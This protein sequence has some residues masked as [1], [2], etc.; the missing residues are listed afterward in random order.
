MASAESAQVDW[1]ASRFDCVERALRLRQGPDPD[2]NI[3]A[4]EW[5][6]PAISRL[7]HGL[8]KVNKLRTE[9]EKTQ[10]KVVKLRED[11]N[12]RI[13]RARQLYDGQL[14][15]EGVLPVERLRE[16]LIDGLLE[17]DQEA[18]KNIAALK[19]EFVTNYI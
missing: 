4:A 2:E 8:D 11:Y 18:E 14:E 3:D 13:N 1:L 15:Q 19:T 6:E 7:R 10:V 12:C 17:I 9:V 5:C 16:L